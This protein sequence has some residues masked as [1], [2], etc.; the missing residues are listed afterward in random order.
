MIFYIPMKMGAAKI[1]HLWRLWQYVDCSQQMTLLFS[2]LYIFNC[3]FWLDLCSKAKFTNLLLRVRHVSWIV[4]YSFAT[5]TLW[6]ELL[7]DS[8]IYWKLTKYLCTHLITSTIYRQL[9]GDFFS[10]V[11]CKPNMLGNI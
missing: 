10:S 5:Y 4:W 1:Y 6:F 3:S 2:F 11:N 8:N 9:N 7:T